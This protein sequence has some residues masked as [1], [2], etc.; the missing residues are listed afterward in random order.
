MTEKKRFS[1]IRDVANLAG[2]SAATVSRVINNSGFIADATRKKV[3]QAIQDCNYTPNAAASTIF[4]G[5]SRTIALFALDISNPFYV[6]FFRHLNRIAL[7]NNYTLIL[8]ETEYSLEKEKKYYEYCKS[9]RARGIVYTAGVSRVNF[10]LDD[11]NAL[12]MVLIDRERFE[13]VPSYMLHS[14]NNKSLKLLVSYLFN[15]NHRRIAYISGNKDSLSG[16]E[17][18]Q[19]FYQY[20]RAHGMTVHE[21]YVF[22]ESFSIESGMKAFDYFS[23]LPSPPTAVIAA[24]DQVASGFILRANSLGSSIPNDYSVCGIDAVDKQFYPQITSV[25]QDIEALAQCSFD[26]IVNSNENPPPQRKILDVSLIL[27]QTCRRLPDS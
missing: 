22:A 3:L 10:G 17:R 4:S 18:L 26:F 1:N 25:R 16:N 19:A 7:E 20:M 23:S 6:A 14:D 13:D 24:S 21:E 8:C 11:S 27:G 5:T 2:V 15:L 9:I 12:P